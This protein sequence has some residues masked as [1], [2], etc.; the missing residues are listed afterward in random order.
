M[1]IRVLQFTKN[2]SVLSS[3]V[4][5]CPAQGSLELYN[6]FSMSSN[7]ELKLF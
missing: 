3:L 1:C 7:N 6:A 5:F 4:E 2:S